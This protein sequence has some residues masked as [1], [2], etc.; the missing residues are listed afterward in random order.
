MRPSIAASVHEWCLSWAPFSFFSPATFL[1]VL[2]PFRHHLKRKKFCCA[3]CDLLNERKKFCII[4]GSIL[5]L[6]SGSPCALILPHKK[7][8]AQTECS[9][10][11][12]KNYS[13]R[14]ASQQVSEACTLCCQNL[15]HLRLPSHPPPIQTHHPTTTRKFH[16]TECSRSCLP[17]GKQVDSNPLKAPTLLT[18]FSGLGL[19]RRGSLTPAKIWPWFTRKTGREQITLRKRIP[20][21]IN[22]SCPLFFCSRPPNKIDISEPWWCLWTV[23]LSKLKGFFRVFFS[24]PSFFYSYPFLL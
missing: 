16:I 3:I 14:N 12:H 13:H 2:S 21:D 8:M 22:S 24:F 19:N 6:S 4:R 9:A 17:G 20:E 7:R 23:N 1:A 11:R 5:S 18:R 10:T 15:H